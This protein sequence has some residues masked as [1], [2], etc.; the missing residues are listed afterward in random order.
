MATV[1]TMTRV[2]FE[3]AAN[4]G[5]VYHNTI[6]MTEG[7]Y[8]AIYRLPAGEIYAIVASL[9]GTGSIE[10]TLDDPATFAGG[11]PAFVAWDGLSNINKAVTGFRVA[12]TSG[13]VVAK[14]TVKTAE[15]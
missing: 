3:G 7:D 2:A 5:A 11:S 13:T 12:Y 1:N 9:S 4:G 6:T 10:F 8:S 14:V 15:A